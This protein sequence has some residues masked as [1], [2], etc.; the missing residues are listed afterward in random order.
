VA[1]G[2]C[3]RPP[4]LSTSISSSHTDTVSSLYSIFCISKHKMANSMSSAIVD[5]NLTEFLDSEV[6]D[7][8]IVGGGTSGLVVASRLTEDPKVKVIVLEAGSNR[9]SDPRIV[10][11]GLAASLYDDPEFDWCFMSTPQVITL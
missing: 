7:Y 3:H 5:P 9:L 1:P 2:V 11:P 6:F 8:V 10:T 4:L